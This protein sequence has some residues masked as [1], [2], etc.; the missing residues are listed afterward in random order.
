MSTL[1]GANQPL[2]VN[3]PDER[4]L[5]K[6][7]FLV[8]SAIL[9][10]G[11]I[12]WFYN[13]IIYNDQVFDIYTNLQLAGITLMPY[14]ISAAIAAITAMCIMNFIPL[15]KSKL[16]AYQLAVRIRE[17][18]EGDLST[19]SRLN[20]RNDQLKE[21]STELSMAV[22]NWNSKMSQMK[23]INRQQW[24]L[25]QDI[26]SRASKNDGQEILNHVQKMEN[27]WIKIAEIEEF[28]NS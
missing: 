28:I 23:I 16:P 12:I 4:I 18:G 11:G 25:L 20:C 27:N 3:L 17:F 8:G 13:Q 15:A 26:K 5:G 14:M 1:T 21:I 24:D 19:F 7:G 6:I 2:S 22:N 9:L 10:S